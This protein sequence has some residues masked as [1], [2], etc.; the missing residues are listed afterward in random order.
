VKNKAP[1]N[2]ESLSELHRMLGLPKPRH[3][4]VSFYRFET[5]GLRDEHMLDMFT[6]GYYSI[7]IKRNFKGKI[8]Y[9]Q[10]FYD[11]D[12]GVMSFIAPGQLLGSSVGTIPAE[13]GFCLMFHPEFLKGYAL[14]ADIKHYN[15]FSY[16]LNEALHLSDEEEQLVEKLMLEI[17]QEYATAIDALS[18]DLMITRITLLLQY[19]QRFYNR[20]F[21]TRKPVN[22]DLLAK[23]DQILE[24][25]FDDGSATA[26]GLPA[27]PYIAGKL[28]VSAGY[29]SD[30]LRAITGQSTQSHIHNKL[31]ERTKMLLGTTGMSI[32]E[33]AYILGFE[34]PQSLSKLFKSK[35]NLSP[36]EYRNQ[37][38]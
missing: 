27:V 3:P 29:L 10:S 36:T 18:H 37:L 31:I 4:L 17:E 8:R 23:L 33:V 35:T 11:F 16:E 28:N 32:A 6:T 20:Q 30:M 13:E 34:R 15:F 2:I 26:N 22:S 5:M 19:C 9:G 7:A 1:Y 21:N 38:Q 14:S 12:E 24:E 25:Y